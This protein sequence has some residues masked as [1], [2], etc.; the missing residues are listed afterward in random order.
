MYETFK[1]HGL[2]YN[3]LETRNLSVAS[4]VC[5]IGKCGGKYVFRV[6]TLSIKN[7]PSINVTT[8][9]TNGTA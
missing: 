5:K 7:G 6:S 4:N 2:R 1:N 3:D 9:K 8:N